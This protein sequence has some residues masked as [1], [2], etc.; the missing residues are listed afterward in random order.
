M[1]KFRLLKDL[2]LLK[3]GAVFVQHRIADSYR[4]PSE[5]PEVLY[6]VYDAEVVE[7]GFTW[8]EEVKE[9]EKKWTDEDMQMFLSLYAEKWE[10][11][12]GELT[13]QECLADFKKRN[14]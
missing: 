10:A 3:A 12:P 9:E 6:Y 14:L 7:N 11:P 4:C 13:V 2:P 8:F 5:T 1:R